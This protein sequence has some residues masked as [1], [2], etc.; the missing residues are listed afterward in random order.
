MVVHRERCVMGG[1]SDGT[2]VGRPI[3]MAGIGERPVASI[4]KG[5]RRDRSRHGYLWCRV[6]KRMLS[7]A[8]LRKKAGEGTTDPCCRI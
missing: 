3:V 4:Y 2:A 8:R 7:T 1:G 6:R 5:V